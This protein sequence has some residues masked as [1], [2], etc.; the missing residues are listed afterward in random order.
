MKF[1]YKKIKFKPTP[2][3][4]ERKYLYKPII[5]VIL[6]YK[7]FSI[8]YEALIDSGADISIFHAEIAELLGIVVKKGKM[9]TFGGITGDGAKAY[10]HNLTLETGGIK[11]ENI[12]IG[13]SYGISPQGYGILGQAGF[14]DKFR[15]I[16][17][18]KKEQIELRPKTR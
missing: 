16:F 7:K 6:H 10:F 18:L 14:F 15:I 17:D 4:P 12:P 2:A 8:G 1:K 13:F 11:F 5:P 9:E 3:F